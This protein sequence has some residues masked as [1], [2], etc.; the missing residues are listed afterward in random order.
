M[1]ERKNNEKEKERYSYVNI[2][3]LGRPILA[4]MIKTLQEKIEKEEERLKSSRMKDKAKRE[5]ERRKK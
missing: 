4:N 1:K 3:K 2:E 5:S